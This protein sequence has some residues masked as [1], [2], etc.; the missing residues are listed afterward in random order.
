MSTTLTTP[1][2][3]KI[4]LRT[5]ARN[6]YWG[7]HDRESHRCQNCGADGRLEVHHRDGDPFNNHPMNLIALC[8]RCHKRVHRM[9]RHAEQ[10][11]D[12]KKRI[13]TLG[14]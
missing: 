10:M 2:R 5:T 13:E 11:N 3:I 9:Q 6:I 4:R 8:Y 1:Q 7:E 14:D 12:W